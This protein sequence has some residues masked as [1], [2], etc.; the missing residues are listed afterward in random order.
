MPI[1]AWTVLGIPDHRLQRELEATGAQPGRGAIAGHQVPLASWSEPK[2][3]IPALDRM[4]EDHN[5]EVRKQPPAASDR[6][7]CK[8]ESRQRNGNAG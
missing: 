4:R 8:A 1:V 7:K 2:E 6:I 5:A 3:T